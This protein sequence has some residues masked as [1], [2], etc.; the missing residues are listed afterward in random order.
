M[1]IKKEWYTENRQ[2]HTSLYRI[3]FY[4]Y[5]SIPLGYP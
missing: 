1:T 2:G 5:F 3:G 4:V